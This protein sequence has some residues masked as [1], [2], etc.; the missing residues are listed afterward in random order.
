M[1]IWNEKASGSGGK[2][3]RPAEEK[4]LKDP[5]HDYIHVRD[6]LVWRLINTR[7]FQR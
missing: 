5:V 1:V 7:V 4:V 6:P 3:M 2:G